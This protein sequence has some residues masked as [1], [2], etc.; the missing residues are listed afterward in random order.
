MTCRGSLPAIVY[1]VK[2]ML[3]RGTGIGNISIV[4]KMSITKGLKVLKSAKY[5]IKPKQNHYDCLETDEFWE[6]IYKV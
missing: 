1:L 5:Q 4:L 2:I 6:V 3:V